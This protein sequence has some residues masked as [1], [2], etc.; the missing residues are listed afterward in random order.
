M[1]DF[2][3]LP[4]I[5]EWKAIAEQGLWAADVTADQATVTQH[6]AS[7]HAPIERSMWIDP[8]KQEPDDIRMLL[9]LILLQ[10]GMIGDETTRHEMELWSVSYLRGHWSGLSD[11]TA[12]EVLLRLQRNFV[13][14]EDWRAF[15]K[16]T[17]QVVRGVLA[18]EYQGQAGRGKAR[19]GT[20]LIQQ[21]A[22]RLEAEGLATS[23]QTLYRWKAKG[24]LYGRNLDELMV[25][26][27]TVAQPKHRRAELFEEGRKRG[28]SDDN[29]K[30]LFQRKKKPDGTP[31]DEAIEAHIKRHDKET[32]SM[33][34]TMDVL[35]LEV[36]R[37][38][39]EERQAEA[40]LGSDAWCE[41]Q[42]ALQRLQRPQSSTH[43]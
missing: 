43:P 14:P 2:A 6:L 10:E 35:S 16:H 9:L 5:D 41:A 42:D 27:R 33:A 19:T 25:Q 28:L 40:P 1:A 20:R 34:S 12:Y 7:H 36:Q 17:R 32:K 11:D 8:R 15:L 18:E 3:V 13:W 4:S 38:A 31:D 21:V 39:W 30:K 24:I 37:V 26:A 29:M 22:T 23:E